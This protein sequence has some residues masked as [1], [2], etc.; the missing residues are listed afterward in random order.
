MVARAKQPQPTQTPP[1][2]HG[3]EIGGYVELVDTLR[4][5]SARVEYSNEIDPTL[6]D[7]PGQVIK[8]NGIE[9]QVFEF[10][11]ESV[12]EASA[13]QISADGSSIGATM[14]NWVDQP[15]FWGKGRVVVLYVGQDTATI[16]LLT[17]VLGEP[18]AQG[19]PPVFESSLTNTKWEL[20]S[21]GWPGAHTGVEATY[22][23]DGSTITLEFGMNG[24]A[25]GSGGCNSYTTHYEVRGDMLST[26]QIISTLGAC[27]TEGVNQQEQRYYQALEAAK[28][29]EQTEDHLVIWY[30]D[31][32]DV[33]FFFPW[34]E[35]T[36]TPTATS[37]P[38]AA[39]QPTSTPPTP[40]NRPTPTPERI[41]FETGATSATI[42]GNLQPSGSDFYV[43][44]ALRG[45]TMTVELDFTEGQAILAIWGEDGAL[46]P[47][48]SLQL[49][50]QSTFQPG[51][52]HS[53]EGYAG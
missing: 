26:G 1:I 4:A 8:V 40:S 29:L 21:F 37:T 23:I 35:S 41:T 44:R 18:V 7:V 30:G 46:R 38:Y 47:C 42:R 32:Q 45:Q 15:N 6:F 19:Q 52:F 27:Q 36:G 31:R 39:V 13:E 25:G 12:R 10:T 20:Y 14:I 50:G 24:Q 48:R 16:R 11:D 34:R 3:N 43:L 22:V 2:S 33:L 49:P 5:Q 9:V 17:S 53:P 51:L 28:V